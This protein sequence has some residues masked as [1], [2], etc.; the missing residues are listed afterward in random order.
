[1]YIQHNDH[2]VSSNIQQNQKSTQRLKFHCLFINI[3][4]QEF[5]FEAQISDTVLH[6][7]ICNVLKVNA[8]A[9]THW[10]VVVGTAS[11]D[12]EKQFFVVL[13]NLSEKTKQKCIP[14]TSIF[15]ILF[16]MCIELTIL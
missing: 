5:Y 9:D 7:D 12:D 11:C 10:H 13:Q 1:M 2:N 4:L 16:K 3:D 15:T 14:L 8:F 6:I